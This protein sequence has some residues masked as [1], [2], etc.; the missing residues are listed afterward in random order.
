MGWVISRRASSEVVTVRT[1]W[2]RAKL[3]RQRVRTL[4]GA[5]DDTCSNKNNKNTKLK[6][7]RV[8][9]VELASSNG[10]STC[11]FSQSLVIGSHVWTCLDFTKKIKS[12]P[13]IELLQLEEVTISKNIWG[14]FATWNVVL[15]LSLDQDLGKTTLL[16]LTVTHTNAHNRPLILSNIDKMQCFLIQ[17]V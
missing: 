16:G 11:L 3:D 14:L 1:D 15:C 8:Y 6:W 2:L 13:G 4:C 10:N 5:W 9:I 17:N 12:G 7:Q